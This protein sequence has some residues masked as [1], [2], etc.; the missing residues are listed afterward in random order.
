MSLFALEAVSLASLAAVPPA[1]APAGTMSLVDCGFQSLDLSKITGTGE[2][3]RLTISFTRRAGRN[4]AIDAASLRVVD[5]T[6]LLAGLRMSKTA[7][8]YIGECTAEGLADAAARL[9]ALRNEQ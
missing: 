1:A 6:S 5:P 9:D 2:S 7:R 3:R 4:P 8:S